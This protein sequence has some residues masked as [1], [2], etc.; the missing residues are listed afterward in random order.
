MMKRVYTLYRVST[1]GQ[2]DKQKDDIPMQRLSCHEFAKNL[3]WVIEKEFEEK[4]I[5]GF[6]VSAKDRDAIQDL[7]VAAKKKQFDVLL[8]FMFDRIGRID[9]ET[10]FVVE[11]FVKHGI[12]VWSVKEGEQRF[13]NHVDK[14]TNYIRFWQAS[15]ESEKTSIRIKTRME[16]LTLEGCYTGGPVPYGY[17]LVDKGRINKKG[18]KVLDISIEPQEAD[19]VRAIFWK[20]INEGY[21]SHRLASYL[22]DKGLRTHNGC[23]FQSV[24]I[25]RILRNPRYCGFLQN[26]KVTS[27]VLTGLRIVEPEV[28]EHAQ[29]ILDQRGE[30]DVEKRHISMNTKGN[31]LLSGNVHCAHCGGS[32][33]TWRYQ[34][35]YKRKDG[36]EY[37]VD[38]LKYLCY[39]RSR[40]LRECDGQSTYKA[41]KIDEIVCEVMLNLFSMMKDVPNKSKLQAKLDKRIHDQNEVRHKLEGE[42]EKYKLQ[43]QSLQ[44][45]IAKSLIGDSLYA[46]ED[47]KTAIE[48]V[49]IR[50]M[51]AEKEYSDLYYD[52]S[53]HNRITVASLPEYKQF[54]T[55]AEEFETASLAQ[56]KMI[57]C[58]LFS[59]I[60]LEKGYKIRCTLNMSYKQFC[61][62]WCDALSAEQFG[63]AP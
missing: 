17:Q 52:G 25:N 45:E 26:G 56:K 38:E 6:K 39:H 32:M 35:R 51:D 46:P 14:L 50:I 27:E 53:N 12:E 47:L 4:G 62:D 49:K 31:A 9:D 16:Q 36:S 13:D 61:E 19:I 30:V 54:K 55:W 48:A 18:I 23:K 58:Q 43:L 3:G 24:A 5:S 21:G 28:F 22:N 10:P 11:W 41:A 60:D 42:L 15:G 40:K 63:K 33:V 59:R 20:T 8:V 44:L 1:K 37:A 34:D 29:R 2:V 57:A 7:K